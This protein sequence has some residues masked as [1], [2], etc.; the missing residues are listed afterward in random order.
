MCGVRW[1]SCAVD[2][3]TIRRFTF[4]QF[5]SP[6]VEASQRE[7][8]A[9]L[10]CRLSYDV[11]SRSEESC[12]LQQFFNNTIC[13]ARADPHRTARLQSRPS[14]HDGPSWHYPSGRPGLLRFQAAGAS[15]ERPPETP[16][17]SS[18]PSCHR[19]HPVL[20]HHAPRSRRWPTASGAAA[21]T[22]ASP[23]AAAGPA[24]GPRRRL[25]LSPCAR[26]G[27]SAGGRGRAASCPGRIGACP[28][29]GRSRS[30]R[31]AGG[32]GPSRGGR[33]RGSTVGGPGSGG[34]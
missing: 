8:H 14:L 6:T 9:R 33:E 19:I 7:E 12:C 2:R 24:P 23:T 1:R 22:A 5:A 21:A 32:A 31:G 26:E 20:Q 13:L 27:G 30:T 34:R 4:G 17:T 16:P 18:S 29:R 11:R 28:G 3:N 25:R 10:P 15:R